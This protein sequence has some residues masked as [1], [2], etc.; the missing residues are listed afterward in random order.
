MSPWFGGNRSTSAVSSSRGEREGA[1]SV[2]SNTLLAVDAAAGPI[3]S[4][5]RKY[6]IFTPPVLKNFKF[7]S[8]ND[9]SPENHLVAI[10][11]GGRDRFNGDRIGFVFSFKRNDN[12]TG[13]GTERNHRREIAQFIKMQNFCEQ[14]SMTEEQVASA[15]F[16]SLEEKVMRGCLLAVVLSPSTEFTSVRK[17]D[18]VTKIVASLIK[19]DLPAYSGDNHRL[20]HDELT[21]IL[22]QQEAAASKFILMTDTR[23]KLLKVIDKLA[24]DIAES[25]VVRKWFGT[26]DDNDE[27]DEEDEEDEEDD[28]DEGDEVDE[29]V[30]G[31]PCDSVK[32]QKRP[33]S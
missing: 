18:D 25:P 20:H 30:S 16:N 17:H 7:F 33:A 19:M 22:E 12:A 26:L 3:V 21:K 11:Y 28:N 27:G 2:I 31:T 13:G 9:H 24:R 4:F 32:R 10:L 8:M 23:E 14:E 15:I 29:V 1:R 6:Y 5:I